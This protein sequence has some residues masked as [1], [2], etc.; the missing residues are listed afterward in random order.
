MDE[1]KDYPFDDV[2]RQARELVSQGHLVFQCFTCA[3]CGA[4]IG[5]TAPNNFWTF[6]HC[7]ECGGITDCKARGCNFGINRDANKTNSRELHVHDSPIDRGHHKPTHPAPP[8][9]Q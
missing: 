5:V 7:E 6:V 8:R 2:L 1:P 3:G 9:K 4:R